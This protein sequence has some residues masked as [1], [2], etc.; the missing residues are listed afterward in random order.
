[1]DIS[2][3]TSGCELLGPFPRPLPQQFTSQQRGQAQRMYVTATTT[4]TTTTTTTA[5]TITKYG[6]LRQAYRPVALQTAALCTASLCKKVSLTTARSCIGRVVGRRFAPYGGPHL[7]IQ[8]H[9]CF[10][11]TNQQKK[12]TTCMLFFKQKKNM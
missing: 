3:Q 2:H 10:N 5:T 6:C 7:S 4:T 11:T 9:C 1:M 8:K 12:N